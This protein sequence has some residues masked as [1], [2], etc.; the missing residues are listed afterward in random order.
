MASATDLI[1]EVLKLVYHYKFSCLIT[2]FTA[3]FLTE[4]YAR[5]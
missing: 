3:Q 5:L 4:R 2:S 1:A